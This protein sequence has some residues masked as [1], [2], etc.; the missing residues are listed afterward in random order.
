V[1]EIARR[2]KKDF[3]NVTRIVEKLEK[4]GYVSKT[5]SKKDSRISNVFILPKAD[6]IKEDIQD[7]WKQASDIAL[8]EV[9][10]KEQE[11]LMEILAKIEKNVSKSLE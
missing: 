2:S 10:E 7:V 4:Q 1:G 8:N 9:S 5:K 3:A 11:Q 6:E